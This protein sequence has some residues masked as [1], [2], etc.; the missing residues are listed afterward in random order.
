[1]NLEIVVHCALLGFAVLMMDRRAGRARERIAQLEG[2]VAR[3]TSVVVDADPELK[4]KLLSSAASASPL[5]P[6]LTDKDAEAL[7][8]SLEALRPGADAE[9]LLLYLRRIPDERIFQ[10]LVA[11]VHSVYRHRLYAAWHR[12]QNGLDP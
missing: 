11:A 3:L 6:V 2:Q 12:L 1:M 4:Q 9:V 8:R 5:L 10:Y 7:R